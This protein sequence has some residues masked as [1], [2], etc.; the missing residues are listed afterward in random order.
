MAN[1]TLTARV[2][3][4]TKNA[5]SALKRLDKKINQIN[6]AVNK[7]K[8]T[9]LEKQLSR[10]GTQATKLRTKL[11]KVNATLSKTSTTANRVKTA[12]TNA[13]SK[14]QRWASAQQ[15]VNNRL[16]K[17][18]SLLGSVGSKLKTLLGAYVGIQTAGLAI[19]TSDK[20]TSS[21]NLLNNLPGGN[22]KLTSQSMDK[23]YA[24]AQRSR[25][26]YTGMLSNVG[27]TMT[28]AGD[29]FQ[30]NVDNAIRFQE[31]MAKA[32]TVGGASSTE[33][34]T[35][36]YQLVQAL[37]SGILQGDELRSVREGAPIAYKEIEKFAQGV[38]DTEESLKELASQGV[39]TSDIVVAAIMGAEDKIN[40]S[41]KNTNMTFAQT[42]DKIK[43][44]TTKAFEPVLQ[45]LNNALA[46]P[47]VQQGIDALGQGMVIVGNILS[48][49][50]SLVSWVFNIFGSFFGW[51]ANNWSWLSKVILT[52]LTIIGVAMA[53]ILFPKFIAWISY[54]GFVITYYVW[55]GAQAVAAGI[56]AALAWMAANWVLL[57]IIVVIAAILV[58]LIWLSDGFSDACG[59]IVGGIMTAVAFVW[60]LFLALADFVLGIVSLFW[61]KFAAFANFFANIFVD[62][63]GSI[64]HLF[65]NMAD[66]VLSVLET[67]ASAMDKVF[68]SNLAGTV[69]KWRGSLDTKITEAV[70]KH[71]NGKYD[72]K[73]SEV[74]LTA[75]SLGLSRW[76]YS[77]AYNTGY[78]WG[79]S[80]GEWIT[81]KLSSLGNMLTD[82]SLPDPNDKSLA[83]GD[84]YDPSG[85]NADIL[86][87]L[88][89]LNG[90]TD[91]IKDSMD[92]RD[93]DLEFLRRIADMEWRKE[94]TTAEIRID[95][96]N[97]NTVN[98]DRDLDGIVD[99]LADVLRDEM[100]VVAEGVHY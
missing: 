7:T 53:V 50:F 43:N 63:I 48:W 81:D 78:K 73:V 89:K 68:G 6:K 26:S 24:A 66:S 56:K 97:N 88:D 94:F 17:T 95:M 18:K 74:K 69:S 40:K 90:T 45:T 12:L 75:E 11:G 54:L 27:K 85:A 77:D 9:N 61:N 87:G 42:W 60:N 80:G 96:T 4:D 98:S 38:F 82:S 14:T 23:T 76:S 32:Y 72:E 52:V 51:C 46:N 57:L 99:Y 67:I 47:A 86:K 1:K 29:S 3:L 71:G 93:D 10:C 37:G 20:I 30:N 36:M 58:A 35:S 44:M 34:H 100:S 5:E 13:S 65:G 64:L 70:K 19:K 59:M 21:K 39:I 2:R 8:A 83:L 15:S 84:S 62:P 41:F 79:H 31:I 55:L 33:A 22:E 28:L 49:V 16:T 25:S 92:L 91:D